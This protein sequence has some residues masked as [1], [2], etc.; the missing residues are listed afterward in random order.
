MAAA[1]T[2][3]EAAVASV[4]T[5]PYFALPPP[6]SPRPQTTSANGSPPT[7]RSPRKSTEDGAAT[8]TAIT[9][10]TIAAS[11]R[12]LPRAA[13]RASSRRAAGT[14]NPVLMRMLAERLAPAVVETADCGRLV[15]GLRSRRRPLPIWRCAGLRGLPLTFPTTTGVPRAM[16]GGLLASAARPAA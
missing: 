2:V 6:K 15:G 8:L 12:L 14:R 1:G 10:A 7:V 4:L 3:D 9:A 13:P 11:I 5:H 16:T